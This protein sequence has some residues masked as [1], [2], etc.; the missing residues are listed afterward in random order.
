M[1]WSSSGRRARPRGMVRDEVLLLVRL[2]QRQKPEA[3]MRR[4]EVEGEDGGT[5]VFVTN[6]L[7]RSAATV[8]AVY[9][10]RWQIELLLKALKQ[11]LRIKTFPGTSANAVL[12]QIWT[13]WSAML[14]V[15]CLQMRSRHG[16]NLSNLAALLRQQL[17]VYR[18][19][20]RWLDHLSEPPPQPPGAE[21]LAFEW[22]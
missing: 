21:P 20:E 18:D 1:E 14:L 6:H 11:T 8:A 10:G 16:W 5:V 4:I 19:F 3:L 9:R 13:A 22:I 15:R 2:E 17:F 7:R 12:I